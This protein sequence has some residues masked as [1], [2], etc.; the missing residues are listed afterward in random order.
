MSTWALAFFIGFFGSVHCI[1]MCGPLAFAVPSFH[2]NRLLVLADKLMY[3]AGRVL[4][5]SVLGVVTG[6]IGR[7]LWLSGMQQSLSI[8]TGILIV[9]AALSRLFKRSVARYTPSAF[10]VPFNRLFGYALKHR[11]NHL[12]VGMLNGL[13]PCGFVYLALAGAVNT[14]TAAN[15]AAYMFFFGLGTLPLMLIATF[16]MGLATPAFRRKINMAIPY[17]M[18]CLGLWFVL[19]G[20]TLDIPYLS[21]A[22]GVETG[23][24]H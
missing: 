16:G 8:V 11:A 15:S 21:P 7:E 22:K 6:I 18:I 19:K 17:L 3:Q 1:G 13:L 23:V 2:S 9:M 4:S 12:I 24:C 5:Y 20:L 10:L 14:G